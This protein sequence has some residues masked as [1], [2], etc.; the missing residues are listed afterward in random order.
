[1]VGHTE[2]HWCYNEKGHY[3]YQDQDRGCGS[4]PPSHKSYLT[5]LEMQPKCYLSNYTYT[6]V[7][8]PTIVGNLEKDITPEPGASIDRPV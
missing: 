8:D 1:M 4:I 2:N 5:P 3:C 7:T 6:K